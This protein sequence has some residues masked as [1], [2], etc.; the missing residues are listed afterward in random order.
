M[1]IVAQNRRSVVNLSNMWGIAIVNGEIFA[2]PNYTE[3]IV[4]GIYE[5][6]RIEEVFKMMLDAI[7]LG[8]SVIY[9]PEK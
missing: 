1:Y 6:E 7:S 4:L 3:R 9:M 5:E 8:S 2:R